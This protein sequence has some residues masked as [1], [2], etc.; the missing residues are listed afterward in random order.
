MLVEVAI[1]SDIMP[2]GMMAVE[3]RGKDIVLCNYDGK[4]YAIERRCGHENA[5]LDM[6]TLEGY[7]LT[8]PLHHVPFDITTGKTLSPPVPRYFGDEFADDNFSRWFG[9]LTACQGL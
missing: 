4:I 3:N 7:I 9:R 6:G 5:P 2:G 8:C 1:T